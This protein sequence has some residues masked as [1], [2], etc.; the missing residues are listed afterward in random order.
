MTYDNRTKFQVDSFN[1]GKIM[2]IAFFLHESKEY[3]FVYN[4]D[5][6]IQRCFIVSHFK[7]IAIILLKKYFRPNLIFCG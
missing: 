3:M 6:V 5:K 7:L 1:F 4:R 2:N